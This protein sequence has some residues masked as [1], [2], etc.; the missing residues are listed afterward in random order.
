[1][2]GDRPTSIFRRQCSSLNSYLKKKTAMK[3]PLYQIDAFTARIF[4]GIPVAV[5]L[6][7]AWLPDDTLRAI[8]AEN[9]LAE[10]G[11]CDPAWRSCRYDGSHQRWRSICV[12][13]QP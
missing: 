9:N 3:L 10:D 8:A 6:L 7:D 1:M 5:V 2:S 12:D 13:M 11:I 4:G